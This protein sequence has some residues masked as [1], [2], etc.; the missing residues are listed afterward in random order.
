M[1]QYLDLY[2]LVN[3]RKANIIKNFFYDYSFE[4]KELAVD[5][6]FP[7]YS[8]IVQY[9]FY[10][11]LALLSYMENDINGEYLIYWQNT[12]ADLDI[13]QFTLQYTSDGSMIV[14]I[15]F[16]CQE[17]A[18]ERSIEL[19]FEFKKYFNATAGYITREEPPPETALEFL[20]FCKAR[21]SPD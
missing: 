13:Y 8:E 12:N 3:D 4:K 10:S 9:V 1:P 21:F 11:D 17:I 5:Y 7:Q 16:P 20:E 14:G 15:S 2:F 18:R 19:F 6:P